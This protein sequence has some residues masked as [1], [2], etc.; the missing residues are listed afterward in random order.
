MNW[1]RELR[2]QSDFLGDWYGA[3]TNQVAHTAM[4]A[5]FAA[6]FASVYRLGFGEMP[7]RPGM[8]ATVTVVYAC[9]ELIWQR[10]ENKDSLIDI[11][12]V[13]IGSAMISL[14]FYQVG[15][16]PGGVTVLHFLHWSFLYVS[17]AWLVVLIP[18]VILRGLSKR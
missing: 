1:W 14:P 17:V 9:I 11:Y 18:Y 3:L 16:L 4:G 8:I 15:L 13:F 10:Y 6:L 7:P 5:F 12:M 2:R